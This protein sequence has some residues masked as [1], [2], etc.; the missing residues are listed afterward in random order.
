MQRYA[1]IMAGGA[2]LRLWPLSRRNKPKQF[3]NAGS[4]KC[5]LVQTVERITEI[6]PADGCYIITNQFYENMTRDVLKGLVPISNIILEPLSQN[7]AACITYAVLL[8]RKKH[9]NGIVCCIP[10]DGYVSNRNAYNSALR[11][12]CE[13]AEI[14]KELVVIGIK[15][16][17]PETGYGYIKADM[18][19]YRD[20]GIVFPVIRFLEKPDI[21]TAKEFVASGEYL[22]NSGIFIASMDVIL[23]NIENYL[24]I[25]FE[26]LSAI[27][28]IKEN[29]NSTLALQQAYRE[30]QAISFDQGVLEKCQDILM[31]YGDFDW[32]DI[33][34]LDALGKTMDT[35]S[36]GNAVIGAHIGIETSNCVIYG[37]SSL[38]ATVGLQNMII[39]NTG[40]VLL[41][42]PKEKAQEIKYLTEVLQHSGYKKYL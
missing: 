12:A 6:I 15:P 26:K 4:D 8:L 31:A 39:V 24:P 41:I 16:T 34:N 27:V 20:K 2:G 40:D 11:T 38:I 32:N 18:N 17:Y 19:K 7:T 21:N 3:L 10:A 37:N 5:M 33:G 30:I 22:W 36:Q 1:V 9:E 42:C 29:T 14:N 23:N 25:L 13:A 35:D 28:E